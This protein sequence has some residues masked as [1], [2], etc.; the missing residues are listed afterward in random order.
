MNKS[1]QYVAFN[2]ENCTDNCYF[3]YVYL[4]NSIFICLSLKIKQAHSTCRWKGFLF[5][6]IKVYKNWITSL[7]TRY[8]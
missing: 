8:V 3:R 2:N 5:K 1:K 7:N 6:S 4:Y